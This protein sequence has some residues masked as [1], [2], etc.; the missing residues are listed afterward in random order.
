MVQT[1]LKQ[2]PVAFW[3]WSKSTLDPINPQTRQSRQSVMTPAMQ[4]FI[5]RLYEND[6]AAGEQHE[7]DPE[8]GLPGGG[9]LTY[10]ISGRAANPLEDLNPHNWD[11]KVAT[12]QPTGS[13]YIMPNIVAWEKD[14]AEEFGT[15]DAQDIKRQFDLVCLMDGALDDREAFEQW[16]ND[17]QRGGASNIRVFIGLVGDG[18]DTHAARAEYEQ[19]AANSRGKVKTVYF[20]GMTDYNVIARTM[21]QFFGL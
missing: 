9:T 21:L 10:V 12:L 19:L 3:D 11:A 15:D 17:P 14:R 4:T 1:P 6:T 7:V 16:L 18:P 2:E 13:T 20:E 8:T 5:T